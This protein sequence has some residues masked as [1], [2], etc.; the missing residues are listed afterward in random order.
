MVVVVVVGS[1]RL[2]TKVRTRETGIATIA[3]KKK[4]LEV[5]VKQGLDPGS[6]KA[7]GKFVVARCIK[8]VTPFQ[9]ADV[10]NYFLHFEKVAGKLKWPNDHWV[11]L[12]QS[13]RVGKSREIYTQLSVEQA[14][15][16]DIVK[17]IIIKGYEY[18]T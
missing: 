13:L 18:C 6:E 9:E 12:V 17:D 16:Y 15:R 7:C 10:D 3:K 14:A 8:L 1:D 4:E 2:F 11:M 5:H